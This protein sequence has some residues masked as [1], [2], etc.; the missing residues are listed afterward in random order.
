MARVRVRAAARKRD[1]RISGNVNPEVNAVAQGVLASCARIYETTPD[2]A[3]WWFGPMAFVA[4]QM[5]LR[6]SIERRELSAE[7]RDATAD[8]LMFAMQ[9]YTRALALDFDVAHF[10]EWVETTD[11]QLAERTDEEGQ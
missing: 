2:G 8:Y 3:I 4:E 10:R 6:L 1:A 5:A 11:R 7:D 9:D